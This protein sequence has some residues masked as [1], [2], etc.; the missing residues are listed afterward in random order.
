M[1][2]KEEFKT[3]FDEM[4]I[5]SAWDHV[6]IDDVGT[7]LFTHIDL[8]VK[9]ILT[10]IDQDHT[11]KLKSVVDALEKQHK[12]VLQ[13]EY[14]KKIEGYELAYDTLE[15]EMSRLIMETGYLRGDI[16]KLKGENQ[17]LFNLLKKEKVC[18]L[19]YSLLTF[20]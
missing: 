13:N 5:L 1:I 6:A 17:V 2:T 18:R 10:D 19:P 16:S 8:R 14:N 7:R 20:P 11:E 12:T 9:Q 15:K 3:I 4:H